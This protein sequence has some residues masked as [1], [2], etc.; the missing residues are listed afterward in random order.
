MEPERPCTNEDASPNGGDAMGRVVNREKSRWNGV[1]HER[2][3]QNES[4]DAEYNHLEREKHIGIV[5]RFYVRI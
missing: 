3:E 2:V 4:Y 1:K 5:L